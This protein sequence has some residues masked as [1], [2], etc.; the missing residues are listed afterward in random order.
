LGDCLIMTIRID[1]TNTAA[2]PGITGSDTDTGLQFGTDEVNIVTGGSTRATVDSSGRV[3]VGIT[4]PSQARLVAQT[5][6]GS[7]IAAVKDNTGASV[8]LGGVTQPRILLEASAAASNFVIYTAGGSS[9]GS[10]SWSEKLRV[11]ADG[12]ITFNG[13]TAAANALDDYEEGTFVPVLGGSTTAGTTANGVGT[14]V[15]IGSLVHFQIRFNNISISGGSGAAL[16]SNMPF[17][18]HAPDGKHPTYSSMHYNVTFNTSR[19]QVWYGNHSQNKIY[20]LE[21]ISNSAWANWDY[22][23]WDNGNIYLNFSGTY[24]TTQ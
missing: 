3:G 11:L 23:D 7:S 16:V 21:N 8:V 4:N 6:S 20:A 17:N 24:Y 19:S 5:S 9:Y 10:A 22:A 1:G 2:N 14:Y 18:I 13:D 12:G 15:K